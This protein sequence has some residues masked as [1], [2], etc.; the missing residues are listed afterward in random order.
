MMRV[1]YRWKVPA[2]NRDQFIE[3]WKLTTNKIHQHTPGALGS[4]C[5][6]NLKDSDEV[7]TIALWESEA[8]WR[9]FIKTAKTGSMNAMHSIAEQI[10]ATPYLQLGDESVTY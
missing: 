4:F 7:L 9:E 8:Q 10:S 6:Q 2:E 5:L 3:K 1:I